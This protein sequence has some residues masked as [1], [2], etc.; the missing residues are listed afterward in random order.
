MC[1]KLSLLLITFSSFLFCCKSDRNL[2]EGHKKPN[3]VLIFTDDQ[4]YGDLSCYGST[5]VK[6]PHIDELAKKGVKLTS[7]YSAS[8]VCSPSR[9][10]LMTGTYPKRIDMATGTGFPVLLAGD[11]KG[12]NP[13]ETTLA[14]L[15]K[16]V[17]YST[18]I[19]GKWHLGDQPE[20][21]P[22]N[23]GF[24]EFFGLPYSHDIHTFHPFQE[25]F[26]FPQLP[27]LENGKV[28]E[29]DP[30]AD[31]LT[32]RITEKAVDFIKRKQDNPFFLYIPHPLPHTP[33]HVSP[34]FMIDV[35]DETLQKLSLEHNTIDY[36]ARNPLYKNAI[37][38]IDWSTG[39]IIKTLEDLGLKDNTLIIFTSDNGPGYGVGTAGPLRGFKGSTFEGGMRE[40]AI[41]YWPGKLPEG[42][43]NDELMTTMDI[44]PTIASI[45]GAELPN[46]VVIDG[47]DILPTLLE[48]QKSPHDAFYYY[49][50]NT[51]EAVRSGEWKMRLKNGRPIELYNLKLDIGESTNVLDENPSIVNA[52]M[53]MTE[54]FKR[55]LNANSR[56]AAF[57][58]NAKPLDITFS[59]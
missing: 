37:S 47:K 16:S 33:V 29:M 52:L 48:Q 30:D 13:N 59:E 20:F 35:D 3:I 45:V 49:N 18:G 42:S 21:L 27:L 17:G 41:I 53:K 51:L 15:L 55:E 10:A 39:Q 57:I 7:F 34:D 2:S 28:I 14:E 12:L 54:L 44:F 22:T 26:N 6:T 5:I 58:E 43:V 9:A 25:R 19:F 32:Q 1:Y 46:N 8:P 36:T 40:P 50:E 11:E 31:Y 23:Q 24:D 56:Q 4:G 38:E